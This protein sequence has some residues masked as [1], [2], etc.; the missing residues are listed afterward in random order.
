[1]LT[2]ATKKLVNSCTH[3]SLHM[4]GTMH[5]LLFCFSDVVSESSTT[6]TNAA[7]VAERIANP[8]LDV[9]THFLTSE[10]KPIGPQVLR[11]LCVDVHR[12]NVFTPVMSCNRYLIPH[13]N[14]V[15]S[16]KGTVAM[17]GYSDLASPTLWRN[18]KKWTRDALVRCGWRNEVRTPLATPWRCWRSVRHAAEAPRLPRG[19]KLPLWSDRLSVACASPLHTH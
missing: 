11:R 3:T 17:R 6:R 12:R 5:K 4:H 10:M 1:M 2:H 7:K 18:C 9:K 14:A 16:Y 19:A 13:G 8:S 15:E